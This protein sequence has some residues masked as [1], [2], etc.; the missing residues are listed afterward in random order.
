LLGIWHASNALAKKKIELVEKKVHML[1]ATIEAGKK[2]NNRRK[3]P[4]TTDEQ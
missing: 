2:V 3:E 4:D 1:H